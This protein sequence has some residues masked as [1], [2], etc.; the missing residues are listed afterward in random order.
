MAGQQLV[1]Q[2]PV[3]A[4][5]KALT[6]ERIVMREKNGMYRMEYALA[7]HYSIVSHNL[8]VTPSTERAKTLVLCDNSL[9]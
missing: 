6:Q 9:G 4:W 3:P 7:R 1:S 2:H 8:A 5:I